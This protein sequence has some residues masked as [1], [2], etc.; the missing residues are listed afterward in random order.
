MTEDPFERAAKAERGVSGSWLITWPCSG[1]FERRPED[2][3]LVM[4]TQAIGSV[5]L[6][7]GLRPRDVATLRRLSDLLDLP[8]GTVLCNRGRRAGQFVAVLDGEVLV[9]RGH[10]TIVCGPGSHFGALELLTQR[11]PDATV[12]SESHVRVLVVEARAFGRLL[13]LV[14]VVSRRL[15]RQVA[16]QVP[17]DSTMFCVDTRVAPPHEY[18]AAAV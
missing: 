17:V 9:R 11:A 6:F 1:G 13:E 16:T 10:R 4:T 15:M 18:S 8:R 7:A 5:P 12:W 2:E 14:P 3:G